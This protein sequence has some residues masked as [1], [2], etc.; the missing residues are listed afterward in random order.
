MRGKHP[1]SPTSDLRPAIILAGGRAQRMGGG[2]KSLL[3]LGQGRV[4]DH[5]LARLRPQCG[6]ISLSANGDPAP[7]SDLGLSLRPDSLPGHPGPLAGVLEGMEWA[8]SLGAARVLSVAADSPFLPQDLWSRL[9]EA[10]GLA[11]AAGLSA[12]GDRRVQPIFGLWPVSLRGPLR[13]AL[14]RGERKV[15]LWAMQNGAVTVDFPQG[16]PPAF[17]NINT[18][19]DLAQAAGWLA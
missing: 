6:P 2:H 15:G 17:F 19:D 4:I 1:S 3:P 13:A 12:E 10:P 9:S 14:L 16:G 7:W 11:I 18:P 5:V 8:A